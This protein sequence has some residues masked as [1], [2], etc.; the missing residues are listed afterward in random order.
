MT[1]ASG[2]SSIIKSTPVIA[3]I[4]LIFLPSLPI[5]LPFISSLGKLTTVI[6]CS[7]AISAAYLCIAVTIRFLAFLSANILAS[8]S[9][10]FIYVATSFDIF[11]FT[12]SISNSLASSLLKFAISCNSFNCSFFSSSTLLFSS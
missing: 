4:V 11:C 10:S 3:S 8:C 12:S 9:C 6:V 2:V 1:T 7:L 5:I